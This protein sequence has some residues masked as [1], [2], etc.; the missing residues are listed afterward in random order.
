MKDST[1]KRTAG[2]ERGAFGPDAIETEMRE[3]V[4]ETIAAI[5]QEELE[6]ALGVA[7]RR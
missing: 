4:R 1:T 2:E 6:A 7:N 3:R 5:V